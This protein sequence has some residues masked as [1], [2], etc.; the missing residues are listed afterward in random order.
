MRRLFAMFFG[1]GLGLAAMFM[2]FQVHVVK[3]DTDWHFVRKQETQLADFYVDI[4]KWD[5]EE[6]SRHPDFQKALVEAGKT[7]LL[8]TPEPEELLNEAMRH[9]DTAKRV[10]EAVRK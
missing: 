5:H 8:P 3:T 10:L 7:E 4:R 2:A 1:F 9:W 6:W